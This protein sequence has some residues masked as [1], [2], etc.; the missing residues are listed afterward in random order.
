M[1]L[2][3]RVESWPMRSP[4]RISGKEFTTAEDSR[5]DDIIIT[6]VQSQRAGK[7]AVPLLETPQNIQ[8]LS[9]ALLEDQASTCW[10]AHC[11]TLPA[12]RRGGVARADDLLRIRSSRPIVP[13]RASSTTC[14]S[15]MAMSPRPR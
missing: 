1:E 4:F 7:T 14:G 11:A 12:F 2:N 6:G 9:T 13:A 3:V 8:V 5:S 15:R 10:T